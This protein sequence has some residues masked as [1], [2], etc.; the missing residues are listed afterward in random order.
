MADTIHCIKKTL[1]LMPTE[2]KMLAEKAKVAGMCEA[3]YIRLLISQKPND[4][5]QIRKLLKDLINEINH[6][7]INVNQIVHSHNMELYMKEDKEKLFAYMR[8][9]NVTVQE[10]VVQIG[11]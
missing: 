8:K 9:L 4:Y 11:D 10:V 2:A 1:R 7:G 3:D 6:I 5:P